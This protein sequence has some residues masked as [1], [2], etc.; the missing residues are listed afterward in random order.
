MIKLNEI[1]DILNIIKSCSKIALKYY[2]K[3]DVEVSFKSDHSPI[4]KADLEISK[5]ATISLKRNF[6]NDVIISEEKK[7]K[8][9][10]FN[11]DRFWLIDPIDGTKEFINKSGN[12]TINFA[13][14]IL[15]KPVFGI[16][17]QPTTSSV[18]YTFNNKS[19]KIVDTFNIE[20]ASIINASYFNEKKPKLICSSNN[21]A[22]GLEN[23][24]KLIKPISIKNIGSSLKFCLMAEGKFTI[25]PRNLP[26]MEWDTAAGHSIL[27]CAGGNIFTLNGVELYYG[28]KNF[29]NKN[30][31]A[32]GKSD[33][34]PSSNFFF[35][36]CGNLKKYKNKID[37][38]VNSLR[39]GKLIIFPTETVYGIGALGSDKKAISS[40]YLAKN[41]PKNNPLIAHFFNI[42][43]IS[44]YVH[45][46]PLALNFACFF[47][48]GPLTLVLNILENNKFSK[49]LSRGRSSLAV[50][51]PS[52]PVALD[53]LKKVN[54]PL[55]APS[56]NKSGGVSPTSPKHVKDDF[57]ELRG[58]KWEIAYILDFE[59]C[60]IGIE[61]TVIDCRKSKPKIL[62][63]GFITAE[64]IKN[65]LGINVY[66]NQNSKD[67]ISPG[68]MK[69]H[70]APKTK[71]LINQK[72]YIE[73]SGCLFFG[74]IP[75]E[76]K[77]CKF[78]YNLSISKNL[79]EA[80]NLLYEG[81]R[82]LDEYNLKYI[83]VLPIPTLGIGKA[84][85][86]RLK[87]AAYD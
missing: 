17:C 72:K 50:R 41:R 11:C 62:R 36:N 38:A 64:K 73:G 10:E 47:W 85:N 22:S 12:F 21:I 23:W 81:L 63:E 1:E 70:Y 9:N 29:K 67:L 45:F 32:F 8:D 83:Q 84:L 69:K 7:I 59:S 79:F 54:Y 48:P 33:Q 44:Q 49:I 82:Y 2:N 5:L 60:E 51:I 13:L 52:H 46:N 76:F 6:K 61:S 14:V 25:Y 26:T 27:K 66:R 35:E 55:L 39:N 58:D 28:K 40:I 56:A 37:L 18:W 71:V 80:S 24:I 57:K 43:Q 3:D 65:D 74:K 87:R 78:K 75:S 31:V 77:E 19:Y 42:E 68:L 30:F 15:G 34:F 53:L 86:D 20:D 4:T 16:I